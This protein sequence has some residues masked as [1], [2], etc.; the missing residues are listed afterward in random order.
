MKSLHPRLFVMIA[1]QKRSHGNHGKRHVTVG[2]LIVVGSV[3]TVWCHKKY[4]H[5]LFLKP[6]GP[7]R[8]DTVV[9][10]SSGCFSS[11]TFKHY[12]LNHL[13]SQEPK[14]EGSKVR[15]AL[16]FS[17]SGFVLHL[18]TSFFPP[19]RLTSFCEKSVLPHAV[20]SGIWVNLFMQVAEKLNSIQCVLVSAK[21]VGCI[22]IIWKGFGASGEKFSHLALCNACDWVCSLHLKWNDHT[23]WKLKTYQ[24]FILKFHAG[25]QNSIKHTARSYLLSFTYTVKSFMKVHCSAVSTWPNFLWKWSVILMKYVL[26][27]HLQMCRCLV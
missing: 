23:R 18:I 1:G 20:Q 4:L 11:R 22:K 24:V 13:Q 16:L 2:N 14:A 15:A 8:H 10:R 6:V 27:T 25:L 5:D 3:C 7:S 26:A 19:S 21:V 17:D 9:Q 12:S